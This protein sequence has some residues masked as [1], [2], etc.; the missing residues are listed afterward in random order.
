MNAYQK[1]KL[2]MVKGLILLCDENPAI[3]GLVVAFQTAV[4]TLKAKLSRLKIRR[5]S[6]RRA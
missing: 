3:V 6:S 5:N 2:L 4:G 1:A